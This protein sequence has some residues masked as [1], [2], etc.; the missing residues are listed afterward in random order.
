[1]KIVASAFLAAALAVTGVHASEIP[2]NGNPVD[3]ACKGTLMPVSPDKI[4][5]WCQAHP[6]G[7]RGQPL[8]THLPR[9]TEG[10]FSR[11]A[12]IPSLASWV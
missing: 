1:M 9:Q 2:P 12:R 4:K 5:A 10:R 8:G 7:Q 11:K 3:W 6:K